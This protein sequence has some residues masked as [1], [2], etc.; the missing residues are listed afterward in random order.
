MRDL[1]VSGDPQQTTRIEVVKV[2][3]ISVPLGI[4][5]E[6]IGLSRKS[7]ETAVSRGELEAHYYGTKPLVL[8]DDLEEYV[9]NLPVE[10]TR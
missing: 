1:A 4:G 8:L 10:S 9:R 7:L 3:K 5:A 2:E 6:L